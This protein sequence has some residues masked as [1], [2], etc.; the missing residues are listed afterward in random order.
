MRW[1]PRGT[2]N[3]ALLRRL[4]LNA[5]GQEQSCRRSLPQKS[6]WAAMDD[7]YMLTVLMACLPDTQTRNELACQ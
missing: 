7:T 3:L 6:N 4:A 5:L 1:A 2:Q